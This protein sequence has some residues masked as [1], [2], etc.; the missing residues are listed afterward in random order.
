MYY[1]MYSLVYNIERA[2]HQN[3]YGLEVS[4]FVYNNISNAPTYFLGLHSTRRLLTRLCLS[5]IALFFPWVSPWQTRCQISSEDS[6][7]HTTIIHT[8]VH[9]LKDI[10]L[11]ST[12]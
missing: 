5:R 1:I 6:N 4:H 11:T 8:S 10:L 3:R 2:E 9:V 12:K 7:K